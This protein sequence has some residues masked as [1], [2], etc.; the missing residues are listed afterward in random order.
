MN[1]DDHAPNNSEAIAIQNDQQNKPS[2]YEEKYPKYTEEEYI[3]LTQ[4]NKNIESG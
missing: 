1:N 4:W 3:E 2:K